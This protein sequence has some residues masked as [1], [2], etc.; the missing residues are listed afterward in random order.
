VCDFCFL[1][2]KSFQAHP[3][4]NSHLSVLSVFSPSSS[5][6]HPALSPHTQTLVDW[7][8]TCAHTMATS[9]ESSVA[10]LSAAT[11]ARCP[12]LTQVLDWLCLCLD[13]HFH[14]LLAM[15]A[16]AD[17]TTVTTTTGDHAMIGTAVIS[18]SGTT[19]G[20][21]HG[22]AG[23]LASQLRA[24]QSLA[25]AQLALGD[26]MHAVTSLARQLL[27]SGAANALPKQAIPVYSIEVFEM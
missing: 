23:S 13:A 20:S 7:L 1:P 16:A 26:R 18:G 2:R 24:L 25:T 15:T 5:S 27:F 10:R 17:T 11:C 12:T 4:F 3:A 9:S 6:P 22:A 14:A 19:S 21:V 8:Q